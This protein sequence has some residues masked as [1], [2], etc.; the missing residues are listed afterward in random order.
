[1]LIKKRLEITHQTANRSSSNSRAGGF[2]FLLV[3]WV[4]LK[5]VFT[6]DVVMYYFC[7]KKVKF[8]KML[9]FKFTDYM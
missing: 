3:S 6:K 9:M 2:H 7:K 1:M 5:S 8:W 4:F